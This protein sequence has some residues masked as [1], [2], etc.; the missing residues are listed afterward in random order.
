MESILSIIP[1]D[2]YLTLLFV[3][4]AIRIF[5]IA[6]TLQ[7]LSKG[8]SVHTTVPFPFIVIMGI[9]VLFIDLGYDAIT[10]L[11]LVIGLAAL[12][13]SYHTSIVLKRDVEK[14]TEKK[15]EVEDKNKEKDNKERELITTKK[16][17]LKALERKLKRKMASL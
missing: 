11:F 16:S 8:K 2:D 4:F 9:S 3:G 12:D 14:I 1:I 15:K 6:P 5:A 7:R 10:N 13:L 17:E